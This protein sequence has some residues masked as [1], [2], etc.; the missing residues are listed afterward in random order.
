MNAAVSLVSFVII[1][2]SCLQFVTI[3]VAI[4]HAAV[5]LQSKMQEW[6]S[7]YQQPPLLLQ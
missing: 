7:P 2:L 6:A 1:I 5:M 3:V 4:M